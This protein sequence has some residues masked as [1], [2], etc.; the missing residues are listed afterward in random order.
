MTDKPNSGRHV[1]ATLFPFLALL[2]ALLITPAHPALGGSKTQ[3]IQFPKGADHLPVYGSCQG[4]RHFVFRA[5]AGQRLEIEL[6]EDSGE[7]TLSIRRRTGK[8]VAGAQNIRS[9]VGD[10]P[11]TGEYIIE[12]TCPNAND[13]S[14]TFEINVALPASKPV[15]PLQD[16]SGQYD[17][18]V[19]TV[20][21]EHHQDGTLRIA[22]IAFYH[23]HTGELC[24]S[25]PFKTNQ[26][27]YRKDGCE[28]DFT[29]ASD[30]VTVHQISSDASCG[31]GLNVT[32]T[33]V[34]RK[35]S[36]KPTDMSQCEG[37]DDQL[38]QPKTK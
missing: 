7:I 14:T 35:T 36:T 16:V 32:A 12:V 34:Y 11:E 5:N 22:L 3:Q 9:W 4:T 23:D 10:L 30:R 17:G 27:Q 13:L 15:P 19:G 8:P 18:D 26:A 25:V 6:N 37:F 38:L 1:C 24:L 31:F 28:I 29:F 21:V 2:S 33:G 20:K